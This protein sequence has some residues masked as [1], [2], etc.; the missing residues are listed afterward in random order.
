MHQAI[1]TT[2]R[3]FALTVL[4]F[5]S[6]V[7]PAAAQSNADLEAFLQKFPITDGEP[8]N[9]PVTYFIDIWNYG[10][11]AA[12]NVVLTDVL[13]PGATFISTS[14]D[15]CS[16]DDPTRTFSCQFGTVDPV[17]GYS[18]DLV[19]Q[20]PAT[21]GPMVNTV[22]VSSTTHDPFPDN[23]SSSLTID[24]VTFQLAD[25]AVDVQVSAPSVKVHSA[26]TFTSTIH[27][28][29][30]S[31][32]T[33]AT[34]SASAPFLSDIV[35]VKPSQGFCTTTDGDITCHLGAMASGATAT[36]ALTVKPQK[37][38]LVLT[39]ASVSGEDD[40]AFFDPDDS[41]NFGSAVADAYYPGNADPAFSTKQRLDVP[42]ATLYLNPCNGEVLA[43]N[44]VEHEVMTTSTTPANKWVRQR[45]FISYQDLNGVGLTTGT[46][47]RVSGIT[48]QSE[49]VF[50]GFFPRDFTTVDTLKLIPNGGGDT[51][52]LHQNTHVTI[53]TDG[54]V[55]A[56]V[57][58]ARIECK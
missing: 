3:V 39:F 41:N 49:S 16:Y 20:T 14:T 12:E 36:V 28:N 6:V 17:T 33:A 23:N 25:L 31:T 38:G 24:V 4:A 30:P 42:I 27:N 29:G 34:W 46:A 57:D 21:E 52:M 56:V 45:L 18:A 7:A 8:P 15:G 58:N 48:K 32:A 1:R 2:V 5:V 26:V 55:T 44:G 10:P 9:S 13:P 22:H 54:T 43:V 53:H 19:L 47:Y 37:D 50:E 11:D 51:L 40:P 35:S